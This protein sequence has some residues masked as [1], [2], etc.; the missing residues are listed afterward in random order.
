MLKQALKQVQKY[1]FKSKINDSEFRN[2]VLWFKSRSAQIKNRQLAVFLCLGICWS[3]ALLFNLQKFK[4][5]KFRILRSWWH[6][7]K[8]EFV[9]ENFFFLQPCHAEVDRAHAVGWWWPGCSVLW[10]VT[11]LFLETNLVR[12]TVSRTLYIHKE[13]IAI[14]KQLLDISISPFIF[15]RRRVR[16]HSRL[17]DPSLVIP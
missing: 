10:R 2:K 14:T 17:A 15:P 8:T 5:R 6:S 3:L 9:S 1:I 16:I 4:R 13:Y 11:F 7:S 12:K